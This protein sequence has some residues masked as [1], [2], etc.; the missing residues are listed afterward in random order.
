M[1]ISSFSDQ[2]SEVMNQLDALA[3]SRGRASVT[4]SFA[5]TIRGLNILP[6]NPSTLQRDNDT[7]GYVFFTRPSLNLSYDNL[8]KD[9]RTE[10]FLTDDLDTYPAMIRRQLDFLIDRAANQKSSLSSPNNPFIPLLSNQLLNMAA[11][12]DMV[13]DH[14][15]SKS[16]L[17]KESW[18][19]YDGVHRIFNDWDLNCTFRSI[20]GDPVT[21]MIL[22]W[23]IYGLSVFAG[24]MTPR[25][26]YIF[27][28]VID[29][30][31]AIYRFVMTPDY[32]YIK[33]AA[34]TIGF[35][36]GCSTG[37]KFS[38]NASDLYST[39]NDQISVPFKCFGMDFS[40]PIIL[41]EFNVTVLRCNR[42]FF[43]NIRTAKWR[44]LSPNEYSAFNHEALPYIDENTGEFQWWIRKST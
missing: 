21:K 22:L 11:W 6:M 10:I 2:L 34:K 29:Y 14:Y 4:E 28:N 7:Q 44:R 18:G 31:T 1:A 27:R 42:D 33:D 3:R 26:S 16:G 24:D 40:D 13:A 36:I 19:M 41:R 39:E 23:V 35:P 17:Y 15:V 30:Q 5:K 20:L 38:F 25:E 37:G 12:P 9:R 32:R 8:I 43:P